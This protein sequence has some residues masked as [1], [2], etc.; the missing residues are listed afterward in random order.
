MHARRREERPTHR[1]DRDRREHQ[2]R[3]EIDGP[4]EDRA[5]RPRDVEAED[6]VDQ[7][8]DRA[9]RD[10]Q[11]TPEDEGVRE[12]PHVVR[13]LQQLALAEVDDELVAD[14]APR[15]VDPRLIAAKPHV[16]VEPV[17]PPQ[18]RAETE[19]DEQEEDHAADNEPAGGRGHSLSISSAMT[20]F[21]ISLVPS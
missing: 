1:G 10:D 8:V 5:A 15:V 14:T 18:E 9:D 11:E 20:S 7:E 4:R 13:P 6:A 2:D 17:R 21:M 19:D 12:A 3:E 16:A